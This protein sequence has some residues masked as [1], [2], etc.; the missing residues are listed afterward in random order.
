MPWRSRNR[1]NSVEP[2]SKL[3]ELNRSRTVTLN[4]TKFTV[5]T[6]SEYINDEKATSSCNATTSEAD[7]IKTV[8]E[9]TWATQ[10]ATKPVVESSLISPPPGTLLIVQVTTPVAKVQGAAVSASGTTSAKGETSSNG[11]ALMNLAAGEYA[12]NATKS[13]YVDPN[14]YVNT[15]EDNSTIRLDYLVAGATDRVGYELA[16][17]SALKVKF[18]GGEGDVFTIF[19]PGMSEP[20][21]FGTAG[22]YRTEAETAKTVFPFTSGYTVYAGTCSSD[23]PTTNGQASNP[24]ATIGEGETGTVTVPVVPIKINVQSGTAEKTA[25][26][27]LTGAKVKIADTGCTTTREYSTVSGGLGSKGLPFGKYSFCVS[28]SNKKWSGTFEA[29]STEGVTWSTV[30]N[31]GVNASGVAQFYLGTNP[32]GSPTGVVSGSC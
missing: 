27:K 16:P 21:L 17:A 30:P 19:N 2:V 18:S 31:G 29:K 9:V 25:G 32:S 24:E 10:G 4:G 6:T 5:K 7:E 12:I 22:T 8:S 15:N 13:G 23:L 11:C 3:T 26:E 28:A 20:R 1:S 14:G